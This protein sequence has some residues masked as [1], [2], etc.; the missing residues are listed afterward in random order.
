MAPAAP[1][2][3]PDAAAARPVLGRR[4]LQ[5]RSAGGGRR[6]GCGDH[7]CAGAAGRRTRRRWRWW[8]SG[9]R[10]SGRWCCGC[11]WRW[12]RWRRRRCGGASRGHGQLWLRD[13]ERLSDNDQNVYQ[14]T[15]SFQAPL[16]CAASSVERTRSAGPRYAQVAPCRREK[17]RQHSNRNSNSNS[18]R[19]S[20]RSSS[21]RS[22]TS[23][24]R[25]LTPHAGSAATSAAG[26]A[27]PL[28]LT[29]LGS[30]GVDAPKRIS[31]CSVRWLRSPA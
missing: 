18:N 9:V 23:Y 20:N 6:A 8:E 26:T 10:C 7:A 12:W 13:G 27:T 15:S 29:L 24:S 14:V 3:A 19:S 25:S 21:M 30:A 31:T 1:A 17:R 11:Y 22:D 5:L 4:G 16:S 2:C 28:A